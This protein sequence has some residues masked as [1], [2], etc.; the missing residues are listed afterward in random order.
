MRLGEIGE[1]IVSINMTE[2]IR[3]IKEPGEKLNVWNIG[4][5]VIASTT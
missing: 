1:S 4:L 3:W 5:W 2:A